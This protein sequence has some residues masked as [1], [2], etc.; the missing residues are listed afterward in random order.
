MFCAVSIVP[1][2]LLFLLVGVFR[3]ITSTRPFRLRF[4]KIRPVKNRR[5]YVSDFMLAEAPVGI[6][7]LLFVGIFAAAMSSV[8]SA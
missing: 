8:S 6:K 3:Y 2:M 7:G 1:M 5:T 4:R